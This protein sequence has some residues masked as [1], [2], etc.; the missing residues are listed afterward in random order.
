MTVVG[1]LVFGLVVGFITYRTLVRTADK[2]AV[3][4]LVAV[5]GVIGGGVVT[6]LYDPAGDPF[7]WYAI[8]LA[9]G[10][11]VFFLAY[12]KMNG[13]KALAKVMGDET[14]VLGSPA[15]R[16]APEGPQA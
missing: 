5:V 10:M 11:A 2:A 9:L 4:D 3:T 13:K 1:A 8:G 7:A 12:W 15:P 6:N 16:P 14:V